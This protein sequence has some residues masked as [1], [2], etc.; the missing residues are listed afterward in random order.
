M[1][2]LAGAPAD[3]KRWVR[4]LITGSINTG[5]DFACFAAILRWSDLGPFKANL[6]AFGVAVCVSFLIN[7]LWTFGD[8]RRGS[9]LAFVFWMSAIALTASGLLHRAIDFGAPVA[10]AK[11]SVTLLA[12]VI[13][14]QVMNR[15]VFAT[16]HA[17][18]AL[19]VLIAPFPQ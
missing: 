14:Y 17:L 3:R 7:R 1:R 6:I 16:R 19:V 4:F 2:A 5:V 8:R 9:A 12:A 10:I 18:I 11:L 15:W 13:S